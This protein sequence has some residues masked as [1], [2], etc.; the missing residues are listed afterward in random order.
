MPPHRGAGYRPV[1]RRRPRRIQGESVRPIRKPMIVLRSSVRPRPRFA[2]RTS[3]AM[4]TQEPPR[5]RCLLQSPP[6]IHAD[7]ST[8]GA[9]KAGVR[10]KRNGLPRLC[11]LRFWHSPNALPARYLLAKPDRVVEI[12]LHRLRLAHRRAAQQFAPCVAR[13]RRAASVSI[14]IKIAVAQDEVDIVGRDDAQQHAADS[15]CRQA[16]VACK[17]PVEFG[18]RRFRFPASERERHRRDRSRRLIG[19]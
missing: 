18:C 19:D 3:S 5:R 16:R 4:L 1:G 14:Q 11:H 10:K 8:G 12:L 7:P 13:D 17:R 15:R 6:V 2:D 9:W